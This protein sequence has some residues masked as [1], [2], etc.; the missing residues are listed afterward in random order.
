MKFRAND[1]QHVRFLPPSVEDVLGAGPLCFF[2][3]Q[4]VE[5]LDLRAFAQAGGQEGPRVCHPVL[6]VK[7]W[8]YAYALPVTASR[9]SRSAGR[10]R[11]L[12]KMGVEVALTCTAFNLT[13]MWRLTR[14]V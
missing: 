6:R 11:G 8:L 12:A 7:L 3:H 10:L 5:A 14:V 9:R 2:V 4:V 1:P 13:R